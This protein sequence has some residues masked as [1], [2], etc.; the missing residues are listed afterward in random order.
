MSDRR[1]A[2]RSGLP[3][4]HVVPCDLCVGGHELRAGKMTRADMRHHLGMRAFELC[5]AAF[6]YRREFQRKRQNGGE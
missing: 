1:R 3:A 5:L 6:E 2:R 4:V